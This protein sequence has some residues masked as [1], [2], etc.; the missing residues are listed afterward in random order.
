MVKSI[1]FDEFISLDDIDLVDQAQEVMVKLK[2]KTIWD[3]GVNGKVSKFLDFYY[4][5][6]YF[7][8]DENCILA[9]K[10]YKSENS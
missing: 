10:D 2:N 6:E 3:F 8:G 7:S 4:S 5:K 9:I 1:D